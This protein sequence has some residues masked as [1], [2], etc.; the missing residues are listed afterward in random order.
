MAIVNRIILCF[1]HLLQR[2]ARQLNVKTQQFKFFDSCCFHLMKCFSRRPFLHSIN[3]HYLSN[4]R[5][6]LNCYLNRRSPLDSDKSRFPFDLISLFSAI[7][8]HLKQSGLTWNP[9]CNSNKIRDNF[10][11]RKFEPGADETQI[12][13]KGKCAGYPVNFWNTEMWTMQLAW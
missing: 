6:D 8:H 10:L 1:S 13:I 5:D 7:Y 9:P 2:K 4:E 3:D 11:R 12:L